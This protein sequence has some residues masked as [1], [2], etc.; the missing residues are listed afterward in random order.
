V[1]APSTTSN[2]PKY[3]LTETEYDQLLALHAAGSARFWGAT[4]LHDNRMAT[5][6]TGDVV[7]FTGQD[8]VRAVGEVGVSF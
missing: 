4:S 3:A 2:A 7:L 8:Q 6:Q 5:L 1:P